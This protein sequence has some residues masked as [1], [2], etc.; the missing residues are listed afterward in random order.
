MP[1]ALASILF[2][3]F[4]VLSASL[5]GWAQQPSPPAGIAASATSQQELDRLLAPIALY[6]DALIAQILMA[7]TYPLEVVYAARWSKGHPDIKGK[8]LEDEM[9]K[10]DWAA[11]VKALTAVPQVLNQMSENIGWMQK[12]GDAVLADQK[13][14]LETVQ[15][16]RAKAQAAG[17]L[18]STPEQTVRTE[19]QES[20]SVIIIEPTQ[21]QTVYVPTYDPYSIY[22]PWWYSYPPYYMYPPG[23]YYPPGPRFRLRRVLGRG[24]RGRNH[25]G[26]RRQLEYQ[27]RGWRQLGPSRRASARRRLR[28]QQGGA[29]VQPWWR[30]A[31]GPIARAVPR[32][33]RQR[34]LQL[35]SMDRSQLQNRASAG[36]RASGTGDRAA[37]RD[38]GGRSGGGASTRDLSSRGSGSGFSGASSGSSTRQASSRGSSSRGSMGGSRGGGGGRGGGRR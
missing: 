16:L 10:Q 34:P 3:A 32:A 20:K 38:P 8:A 37:S 33:S 13:A 7:S 29:E 22:G 28:R 14:V 36:N 30:P 31:G 25:V 4:V 17:N 15:S 24:D 11:E 21:S 23:Y 2:V 26:R 19:V 6:P 5:P 18:K 35:Q 27:R 1:R 12:L 9:K